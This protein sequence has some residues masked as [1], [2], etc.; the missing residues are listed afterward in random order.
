MKN[1]RH[2]GEHLIVVNTIP[3][4][5]LEEGG[6]ILSVG[7]VFSIDYSAKETF[8]VY[9]YSTKSYK[10]L[11]VEDE[12]I[13]YFND[14]D[15]V[16]KALIKISNIYENSQVGNIRELF[17]NGAF[18]DILFEVNNKDISFRSLMLS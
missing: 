16:V 6:I 4:K 1:D 14:Y 5:V 18:T 15:S 2:I 12:E 8:E 11:N 9:I 17:N 10:I 13:L 3:H 7:K